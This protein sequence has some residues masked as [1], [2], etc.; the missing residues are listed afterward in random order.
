[1]CFD[2]SNVNI[3]LSKL[4]T[5]RMCVEQFQTTNCTAV[6]SKPN[7]QTYLY[8]KPT[9]SEMHHASHIQLELY[10]QNPYELLKV[11]TR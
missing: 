5:F 3:V 11:Q 7:I 6:R 10:L 2:D 9:L 4:P 8:Q 1:M